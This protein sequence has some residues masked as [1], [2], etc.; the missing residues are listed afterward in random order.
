MLTR[1]TA[2]DFGCIQHVDMA[3]TPIHAFIGPNDSGKSTLLT[4]VRTLSQLAI[5]TLLNAPFVY[6]PRPEGGPE[7]LAWLEAA[8]G[9][10]RYSVY[11]T[12][13][14][15]GALDELLTDAML[16]PRHETGKSSFH[17][18]E[19]TRRVLKQFGPAALVRYDPDRLREPSSFGPPEN[20]FRGRGLG[21]PGLL[22]QVM[23]R[24]DEKFLDLRESFR[25]LFPT[26]KLLKVVPRSEHQIVIEVELHDGTIVPASQMSEGMLFYLG[27]AILKHIA[28]YKIL[29]VEEPETGLH[30]SRIADVMGI[31]RG[32]T[33]GPE[34]TQV[35]IATHS[36]LV[37][38][39]LKP[40]EVS[41]VTRTVE[42][43]TKVTPIT[44]TKNFAKRQEVYALGE[45]WLSYADGELES[46]LVEREESAGAAE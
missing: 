12:R 30:P 10:N 24:G 9:T 34:P 14:G 8:T 18:E 31:L 2:N 29:L 42:H 36:P 45:L 4:A 37:V 19:Q 41:L 6:P 16:Q 20:F 7:G 1:F 39:E 40:D 32:L 17:N 43:G 26:T 5:G 15:P 21:L 25:R 46:E 27:Y 35:L 13:R 22:L 28:P 44:E 11:G 33:E 38:N 23:G 3:L